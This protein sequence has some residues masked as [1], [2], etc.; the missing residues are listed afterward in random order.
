MRATLRVFKKSSTLQGAEE[1]VLVHEWSPAT[2]SNL[3]ITAR[4]VMEDAGF[5][6]SSDNW[7]SLTI[8]LTRS[9]EDDT[10]AIQA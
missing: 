2:I 3:G 5:L 7:D 10:R 1:T 4:H 9:R 6:H 8:E